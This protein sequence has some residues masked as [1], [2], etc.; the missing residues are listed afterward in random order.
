MSDIRSITCGPCLQGDPVIMQFGARLHRSP[1]D[2]T[3]LVVCA[4]SLWFPADRPIAPKVAS[5]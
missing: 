3:Y 2:Q 4:D 1:E 5:A